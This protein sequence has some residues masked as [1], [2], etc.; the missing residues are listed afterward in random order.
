[1]TPIVSVRDL[2]RRLGTTA[3]RLRALVREIDDFRYSH[4]RYWAQMDPKTGKS[5]Q[6]RE[7]LTELKRLQRRIKDNILA[8]IDLSEIA[9][10][11]VCG[12][13]PRSNAEQH[14]DQVCV[15]NMDVKQFFPHVRHYV[16][17]DVLR[18]EYEFGREVAHILTRLMTL[19]AQLPQGAPTSTAAANIVLTKAVDVP[20]SIK[21]NQ[22]NAKA[23][24]FVDDLAFSGDDPRVLINETAR[25]LSSKRLPIWRKKA[26]FQPNRKFKI[27]PRSERQEVTG[28]VVNSAR[29]PSVARDRRNGIRA[30]IHQVAGMENSVDQQIALNSIKGRINHVQQ[31]NPG[32]AAR[33]R[34]Y[35]Q[36]R[37]AQ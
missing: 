26:K 31:F 12:C 8:Q 9:H 32:S 5:R 34:R 14:L 25:A 15:I 36:R 27:T 19:D 11:G 28:L 18:R 17:R 29:G 16:L 2:A 10:G 1:V 37:C 20:L 7:P 24:R 6:F 3:E 33:L 4:Y 22:I 21:A 13:S 30:A 35:L 23:T